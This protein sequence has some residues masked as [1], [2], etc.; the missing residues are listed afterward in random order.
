MLESKAK[1]QVNIK[2]A[3]IE[4]QA[5]QRHNPND[6]LLRGTQDHRSDQPDLA[7]NL[8][9]CV[10]HKAAQHRNTHSAHLFR[11]PY[12]ITVR[13]SCSPSAFWFCAASCTRP[14]ISVRSPGPDCCTCYG[15]QLSKHRA[16]CLTGSQSPNATP[17]RHAS[18][19]PRNIGRPA[20]GA[21]TLAPTVGA[22][23]A[24]HLV[25][26]ALSDTLSPRHARHPIMA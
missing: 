13:A 11:D 6:V 26:R 16:F 9:F 25:I 8:D 1:K 21:E 2:K 22:N 3:M 10:M 24:N 5:G 12:T 15:A 14:C 20:L 19:A 7:Q 18:P 23:I 17:R 4:P